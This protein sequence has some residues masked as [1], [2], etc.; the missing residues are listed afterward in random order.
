MITL[1]GLL[2][3][4]TSLLIRGGEVEGLL[5]ELIVRA[6]WTDQKRNVNIRAT[7]KNR[8]VCAMRVPLGFSWTKN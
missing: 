5:A 7:P 4:T 3:S 6:S 2:S 8:L 1:R